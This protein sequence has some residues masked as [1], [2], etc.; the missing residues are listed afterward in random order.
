MSVLVMFALGGI[1]RAWHLFGQG[2]SCIY[3]LLKG[4]SLEMG[5]CQNIT[6]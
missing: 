6:A 1:D 4:V 2:E 3:L 5:G